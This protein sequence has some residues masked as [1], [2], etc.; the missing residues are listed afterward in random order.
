MPEKEF[1]F[2]YDVCA[3]SDLSAEEKH[4]LQAAADA[5]RTAYA[6]YSNFRVGAAALLSNGQIVS[7]SNQENASFPAG[8]CAEGTALSA[9]ASLHPHVP[10]QKLAIRAQSP[11]KVVEQPVAPCGICRQKLLEHETRYRNNI[12]IILMGETGPVYRIRSAKDL[13]PLSF[14]GNVL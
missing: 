12:E 3:V 4:L 2:R 14:T 13:L 5:L 6:P 7:G 1:S 8:L 10:I 9:A 11:K